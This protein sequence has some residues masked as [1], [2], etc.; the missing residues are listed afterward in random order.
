VT[1]RGQTFTLGNGKTYDQ[2]GNEIDANG[3]IASGAGMAGMSAT[4]FLSLLGSETATNTSTN[5][6]IQNNLG[7]PQTA[8]PAFGAPQTTTVNFYNQAYNS[9]G[10]ADLKQ[11]IADYNDQIAQTNQD[12]INAVSKENENPFL[13]EAARTGRVQNLYNTAQETIAN[14]TNEQA[15]YQNL[16]AQGVNEVNNAVT[17]YTNDFTE[18]QSINQQK[19]NYLLGQAE[20]QEGFAQ[21]T[22]TQQLIQRYYPQYINAYAQTQAAEKPF[23]TPQTGLFTYNPTTKSYTQVSPPVGQVQPDYDSIGTS[24]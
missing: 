18:N 21:N 8:V 5:Q 1:P 22:A 23:G 4:D 3:N 14:L 17:R 16:Y 11:K 9:A 10:L 13:S 6:Q 15:N 24:L 7:I 19:L 2:S 20:K 12:Y